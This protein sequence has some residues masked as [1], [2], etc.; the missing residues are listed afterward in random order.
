MSDAGSISSGALCQRLHQ[1]HVPVD[2]AIGDISLMASIYWQGEM[3]LDEDVGVNALGYPEPARSAFLA[4]EY[5]SSYS[6]INLRA[7]WRSV[8]GSNF[9]LGIWVD[10]LRDEEYVVGGLTVDVSQGWASRVYGAPRT[11]GATLR[12]SF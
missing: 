8:M 6:V 12:W 7:D 4:N 3:S 11:Y 5:E 10:N 1:V 9:D 2:P